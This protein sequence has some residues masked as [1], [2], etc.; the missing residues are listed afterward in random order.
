MEIKTTFTNEIKTVIKK[1]IPN[2]KFSVQLK[3][4]KQSEM[5]YVQIS[6]LNGDVD[7]QDLCSYG[8]QH[9]NQYFPISLNATGNKVNPKLR[10]HYRYH[11]QL[12]SEI[13]EIA[14]AVKQKRKD[15][16]CVLIFCKVLQ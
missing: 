3:H 9:D 11:L 5:D 8:W 14:F 10:K 15:A 2:L 1:D 6:I 16:L 4:T 7:F 12:F 13:L